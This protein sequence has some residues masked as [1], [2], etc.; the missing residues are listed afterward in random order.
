MQ[1]YL[2]SIFNVQGACDDKRVTIWEI[3]KGDIVKELK[4]HKDRV[5]KCNYRPDKTDR[6]LS[7]SADGKM[8]IINKLKIQFILHSKHG[9]N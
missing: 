6:L 2:K 9:N 7:C 4:G 5:H 8:L 3:S 1:H